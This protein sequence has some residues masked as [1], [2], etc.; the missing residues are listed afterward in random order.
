MKKKVVI[1]GGG[2]AGMSAAIR[3]S[4]DNYQ[5][6]LVEKG[7]RLGGKLNVRQGL[8]Y[9]FD[10]GPTVL[11]MPWVFEKLFQTVNRN[12]HEYIE[13]V[14]IEPQWRT[15]FEDGTTIDLTSDLPAMLHE[16]HK[17]SPEDAKEFFQ[18]MH[19]C[20]NMYEYSLKGFFKKSL[21]GLNDLRMMHSVKELLLMEPMKSFEQTNRK[22]FKD[23]K[24]QQ[25]FNHF[26]TKTGSSPY[27]APAA[28]SQLAHI[29]LGQG[30][31]YV[32][33]GMYKIAE[34]MEKVLHELG[35]KV[36]LKSKVTRLVTKG[37]R[38]SSVKLETGYEIEADLVVSNLEAVPAYNTIL[39]DF[40]ESK[41]ASKELEK[42]DPSLSGFVLLLGVNR[43]YKHLAHHNFFFS[44]DP[45]KEHQ[46]LF[47]HGL[48]ADD[49]T[50]YV[51]ISSKSDRSSAPE[52]KENLFVLT[53]VPPLKKGESWY[54]MNEGYRD[55]VLTKLERMG[56]EDLRK[57]IEFEH[58]FTPND[59]QSLY[60]AQGGSLYG[61]VNDRK[62]NGGFKI[63]ARSK[64]LQNLYFVGSSTHPGGGVPMVALSGQLTAD[65]IL[66][67]NMKQ[68][69]YII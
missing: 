67:D 62:R 65:L 6:T 29:Q 61:V 58:S 46:Q 20:S 59:L 39:K 37:K 66:E 47:D 28:L 68:K 24:L 64:V 7:E 26:I 38:V 14:R 32:K 50:V 52:G 33:G 60:G 36:I 10:T 44:E 41:N 35:V 63:P 17:V 30:I 11:T 31:Y 2:L 16:L 22:Y 40:S 69:R 9:K 49:P 27:Q 53:H 15:F 4:A 3:L 55:L 23:K 48:P 57:H 43:E 5:V 13:M 21:S 1:V 19:Y 18:Y 56:V 25:L 51:G 8:G 42:F 54:T 45:K 12:I 34:A